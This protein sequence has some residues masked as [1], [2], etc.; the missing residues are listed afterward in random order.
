MMAKSRILICTSVFVILLLLALVKWIL[1]KS[2]FACSCGL[3]LLGANKSESQKQ[4]NEKKNLFQIWSFKYFL[5]NWTIHLE[6]KQWW[7]KCFVLYANKIIGGFWKQHYNFFV[8]LSTMLQ[9]QI[10]A[11]RTFQKLKFCEMII[12]R[13][14]M[15][16]ITRVNRNILN[17]DSFPWYSCHKVSYNSW[18][19]QKYDFVCH[20]MLCP[21]TTT[22][23]TA[24]LSW[25][26]FFVCEHQYFLVSQ[27]TLLW[28]KTIITRSYEY[29]NRFLKLEMLLDL[30]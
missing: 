5:Q 7:A 22:T 24:S 1:V 23:T 26:F 12:S 15:M 28:S 14:S 18:H 16:S 11:L 2:T 27:Q 17:F 8:F 4:A 9:N 25:R 29:Y 6:F 21:P 3:D 30:K 10:H 20:H 19:R 13:W